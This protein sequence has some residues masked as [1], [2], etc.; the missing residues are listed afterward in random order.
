M[1]S[2][3]LRTVGSLGNCRRRFE[4]L[5]EAIAHDPHQ[6][7]DMKRPADVYAVAHFG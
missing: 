6:A 7:L 5:R 2:M 3:A 1:P 4:G